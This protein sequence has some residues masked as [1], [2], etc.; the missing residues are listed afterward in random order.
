M[1]TNGFTFYEESEDIYAE[2]NRP[3]PI[4]KNKK[5]NWDDER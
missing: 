5:S 1:D 2:L 3:L 4:G